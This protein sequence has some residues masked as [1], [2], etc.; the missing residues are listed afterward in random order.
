MDLKRFT[1]LL[2]LISLPNEV[3]LEKW[4]RL[5]RFR[6]ISST[7][8]LYAKNE[9]HIVLVDYGCG[10]DILL[11]KY[12]DFVHP[13]LSKKIEY[14]GVDPLMPKNTS[15]GKV[16]IYKSK[17][18]DL[19]L[20]VKADIVVMLAVLEHVDD[21]TELIDNALGIIKPNGMIIGTTP[22]PLAKLPLEF[23]SYV[24]GIISVREIEEHKRYPTKNSIESSLQAI[25]RKKRVKLEFVH[26]YFEV[27]MNNF[28]QIKKS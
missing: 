2:S 11:K 5:F 25:Q 3:W 13:Q 19:K 26:H 7:I 12:F 20:S 21:A 18:E 4:A 14:I 15:V 27:G 10:Q 23:L 6:E 28:F 24:L 22:S 9:N 8:S 1:K 16:K 17:F